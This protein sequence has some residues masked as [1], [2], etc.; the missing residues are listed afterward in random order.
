LD[1]KTIARG[2]REL[3]RQGITKGLS[4]SGRVRRPG[5]GR[6]PVESTFPGC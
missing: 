2:Q 3:R 4:S 1:R 5:A 6:K